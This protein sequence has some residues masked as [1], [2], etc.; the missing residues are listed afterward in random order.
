MPMQAQRRGGSTFA[1]YSQPGSRRCWLDSTTL[2]PLWPRTYKFYRRMGGLLSQP[3]E[4]VWCRESTGG[5]VDCWSSLQ[6]SCDVG[7]LPAWGQL[8]A[9]YLW[10]KKILKKPVPCWHGLP[11]RFPVFFLSIQISGFMVCRNRKILSYN[12][13]NKYFPTAFYSTQTATVYLDT[14]IKG[15]YIIVVL[16]YSRVHIWSIAQIS[17]HGMK[18]HF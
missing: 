9:V 1:T 15:V 4:F 18:H 14:R 13:E 10:I 16:G 11:F 3:S 2:R 12:T 8:F 5:W 6:N 7:S 17:Q